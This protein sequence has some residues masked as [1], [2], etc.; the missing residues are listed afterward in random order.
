MKKNN[1][2]KQNIYNKKKLYV[3][4]R[5]MDYHYRSNRNCNICGCNKGLTSVLRK[6][7]EDISQ[8]PKEDWKRII[9]YR[10][11]NGYNYM[12]YEKYYRVAKE[13]GVNMPRDDRPSYVMKG[14]KAPKAQR[15][16]F[17]GVANHAGVSEYV[18]SVNGGGC[19]PK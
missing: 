14:L 17:T 7:P 6:K 4:P 9:S 13:I 2:K 1:K 12:E 15:G 8:I 3:C 16:S 11:T 18:H 5:C 19:S 10:K